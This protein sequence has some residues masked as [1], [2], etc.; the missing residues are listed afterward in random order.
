MKFCSRI[1]ISAL[2]VIAVACPQL[3]GA[4]LIDVSACERILKEAKIEIQGDLPDHVFVN[5]ILVTGS[6]V[7]YNLKVVK[8]DLGLSDDFIRETLLHRKGISVGE[9][10]SGL[11]PY[12]LKNGIDV[13]GVDLWYHREGLPDNHAGNRMRDYI[14]EYGSH[15]VAGSAMNLPFESNSQDFVLSHK[16]VNNLKSEDVLKVVEESVRVLK[17]K[18]SARIYGISDTQIDTIQ[19]HLENKYGKRIRI[20]FEQRVI[21]WEWNG[22]SFSHDDY[23][24]L[25]EKLE[26]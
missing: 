14:R 2:F 6:D 8:E 16:L 7:L 12:L 17:A 19:S 15:L 5:D 22:R 25:I 10:F 20:A 1:F 13:T 9:G 24:L 11:L 18:G 26:F 4:S 23:L 21:A 3:G